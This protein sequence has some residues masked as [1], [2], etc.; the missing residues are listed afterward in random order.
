MSD[1]EVKIVSWPRRI[2]AYFIDSLV[3][4]IVK[5]AYVLFSYFM[6]EDFS[7]PEADS[8]FISGSSSLAFDS[9]F[10]VMMFLIGAGYWIYFE[11]RYGQTVG[12]RFMKAKTVKLDGSGITGVDAMVLAVGKSFPGLLVFDVLIGVVLARGQGQKISNKITNTC[13]VSR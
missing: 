11:Y 5:S 6:F 13:V 7:A 9:L 3:I 2:V 10:D 4:A 12:K 8:L 1:D